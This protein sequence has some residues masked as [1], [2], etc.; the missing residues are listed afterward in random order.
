MK[1][2]L[3]ERSTPSKVSGLL[4][5]EMSVERAGEWWLDQVDRPDS[6][7]SERTRFVYRDAWSRYVVGSSITGLSL[8]EVNSVPV[9]ERWLQTTADKFGTGGAKTARTVLSSVLGR[10]VRY[11][12]LPFNATRDVRPAKAKLTRRGTDRDTTRAFTRAER[13]AV[14]VVADEH[15][16]AQHLDVTDVMF[17]LAGTGV[18][19]GEAL[20]QRWDDVDLDAG[21][22]YVRGTKSASSK[23]LLSMPSWLVERL[24]ARAERLGRGGLVFPSPRAGM[25]PHSPRDRRNVDRIVREVLD[26]AGHPWATSHTFRRTVASLLDAAGMPI[27]LAANQLGHSDAAMTARVYLGRK[28]DNSAAAGVL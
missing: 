22:V 1:A 20:A 21:T 17:L 12:V 4:R 5:A 2:A 28:G 14:L 18:R 25:D 26:E 6:E 23:R 8:R 13:D 24:S 19:I 27:A 3:A 15:E 9:I 10:A 16:R 7:L 11:G